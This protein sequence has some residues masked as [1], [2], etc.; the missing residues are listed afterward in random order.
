MKIDIKG[1][2]VPNDDA[3]IYDWCEI[4]NTPPKKVLDVLEKA[5]GNAVDVYINSGG[6]DVFAGS[7]IY[8][9]LRSY[10]GE[11]SIH[12]VGLAAS[13]ASVVACAGKSDISPTAMVMVHNVHGYANGDWQT[14]SKESDVLKQANRAIASAY[15][16]K[17]GMNEEEALSLMEKETW[18]TAQDAVKLGIVDSVA[19][20]SV[21]L[22]ASTGM[23]PNATLEKI[24]NT[25]FSPCEIE[26]EKNNFEKLKGA[27]K[28]V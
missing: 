25:V 12:I 26:K 5:D 9:A 8:S 7:E 6:G 19:E 1:V 24:R 28:N 10:N 13:A 3:W 11:V 15:C 23:L 2:I 21:K 27:I 18:L 20:Q 22:A 14:M 4:E 16:A 17:T